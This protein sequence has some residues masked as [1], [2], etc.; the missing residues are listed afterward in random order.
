MTAL[1][2]QCPQALGGRGLGRRRVTAY[3]GFPAVSGLLE[4]NVISRRLA[5]SRGATRGHAS[6]IPSLFSPVRRLGS[7]AGA[8]EASR[9]LQSEPDHFLIGPAFNCYWKDECFDVNL[10]S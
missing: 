5:A 1:A 8:D 9:R 4:A 10:P 2:L 7:S 6:H 3:T